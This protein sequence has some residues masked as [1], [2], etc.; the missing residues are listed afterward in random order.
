MPIVA[1]LVKGLKGFFDSFA[2]GHKAEATLTKQN[3]LQSAGNSKLR[4]VLLNRC[5]KQADD[6]IGQLGGDQQAN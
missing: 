1:H 4:S 6:V 5:Q 3:M 2:L